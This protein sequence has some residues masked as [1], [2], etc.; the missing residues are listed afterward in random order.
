MLA[1]SARIGGRDAAA[2]EHAAGRIAATAG[3]CCQVLLQHCALQRRALLLLVSCPCSTTVF[4]FGAMCKPHTL[5]KQVLLFRSK[6]LP[7]PYLCS[8][9]RACFGPALGAVA[10]ELAALEEPLR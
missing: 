6:M 5:S 9:W 4:L 1:Y 3:P 10:L 2:P 8:P 7:G